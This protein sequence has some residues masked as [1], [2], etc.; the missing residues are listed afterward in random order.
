MPIDLRP[1]G[2][3]STEGGCRL[4]PAQP[5]NV[6][7]STPPLAPSLSQSL[8]LYPQIRVGSQALVENGVLQQVRTTFRP[9]RP[10]TPLPPLAA[11][12]P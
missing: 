4:Q 7:W 3:F 9:R 6:R 8:F 2:H 5:W 11:G 1:D 12:C 10:L